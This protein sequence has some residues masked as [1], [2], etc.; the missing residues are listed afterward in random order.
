[1]RFFSLNLELIYTEF[2]KKLKLHSPKW[3]VEFQSYG[4][5]TPAN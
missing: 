2:F 1:M 4:E 3:G 5:L